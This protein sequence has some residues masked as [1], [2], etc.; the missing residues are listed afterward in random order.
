[1]AETV[2]L[3]FGWVVLAGVF[4][5]ATVGTLALVVAEMRYVSEQLV[6][7]QERQDAFDRQLSAERARSAN[8]GDEAKA[9]AAEARERAAVERLVRLE[10]MVRSLEERTGKASASSKSELPRPEL[11]RP[12]VLRPAP[13]PAVTPA[14]RARPKLNAPKLAAASAPAPRVPVTSK[15]PVAD[16][17]LSPAP[18]AGAKPEP[19]VKPAVARRPEPAVAAETQPKLFAEPSR[20]S[21]PIAD[22][23]LGL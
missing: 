14:P 5:V 20:P 3:R 13:T 6:A 23:R 11:P 21:E 16:D 7:V 4:A 17:E 15:A 1:V 8:A 10:A 12:E 19:L 2:K 22:R 18:A 9:V